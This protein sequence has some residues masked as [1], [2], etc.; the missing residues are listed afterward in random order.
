VHNPFL[1]EAL[2]T[3]TISYL[4]TFYGLPDVASGARASTEGLM[5]GVL[6]HAK[7]VAEMGPAR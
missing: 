1:C 3:S 5:G 4:K 6:A 7:R 2:L